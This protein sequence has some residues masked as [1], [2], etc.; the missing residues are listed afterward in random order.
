MDF[1]RILGRFSDDFWQF[2]RKKRKRVEANKTLRGRMNFEGRLF[3]KHAKLAAKLQTKLCKFTIRKKQAKKLLKNLI[4][5]S[6][7]L[8]LG[9]G[10]D[11]LGRLLATFGHILAVFWTLQIVFLES[12][13][14]R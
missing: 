6:L 11:A 7:G 14:P 10:W 4:L 2:F 12:I 8:N 13:G 1:E 3:K 5:E 9:G